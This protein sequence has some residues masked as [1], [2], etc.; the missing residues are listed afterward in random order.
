MFVVDFK[1]LMKLNTV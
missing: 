1:Q